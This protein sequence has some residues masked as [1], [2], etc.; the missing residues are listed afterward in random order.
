MKKFINTNLGV[1][2]I[3][4]LPAI[5]TYITMITNIIMNINITPHIPFIS[6]LGVFLLT[7]TILY[8]RKWICDKIQDSFAHTNDL[9]KAQLIVNNKILEKIK[10]LQDILGVKRSKSLFTDSEWAIIKTLLDE[11]K[12]KK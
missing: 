2:L 10:E 6:A 7:A 1:F 5:I 3:S 4:I 11:D 12:L 8:I 9:R